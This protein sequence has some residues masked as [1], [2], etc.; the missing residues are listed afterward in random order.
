MK[1]KR[2]PK[3]P[4]IGISASLPL[5]VGFGRDERVDD[6]RVRRAAYINE[7]WVH[8]LAAFICWFPKEN[9]SA[10]SIGCQENNH[11]TRGCCKCF[12][13]GVGGAIAS[14]RQRYAENAL[15]NDYRFVH[16]LGMLLFVVRTKMV[17]IS[18][19]TD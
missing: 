16:G 13:E 9:R 10:G 8:V 18:N 17:Y 12:V 7:H 11:V 14:E 3:H 1:V 4:D 2:G 6:M 5:G 15:E 19:I